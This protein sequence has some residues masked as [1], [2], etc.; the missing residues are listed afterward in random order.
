MRTIGYFFG[1]AG[2]WLW[3]ANRSLRGSR[4]VRSLRDVA[5]PATRAKV[6]VGMGRA[7]GWGW[8]GHLAER[9]G[10]EPMSVSFVRFVWTVALACFGTAA[11]RG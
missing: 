3:Q 2:F 11:Y 9:Q 4:W 1:P 5:D 6:A 10:P 7:F 8:E